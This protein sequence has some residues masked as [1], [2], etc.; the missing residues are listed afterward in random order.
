M[1]PLKTQKSRLPATDID[2]RA[3]LKLF[4]SGIALS[5]ASCSKPVEEIVPYVEQPE[6]LVPGIPLRFATALDLA[7]FSR[8]VIVTSVEGRPIKIEGNPRH[9]ASLGATDVFAEAAVLS[10]Y[11][12]D[13]SKTP[14]GTIDVASWSD[15]QSALRAQMDKESARG[16]AG[17]RIVSGRVT[18]P[19]LARQ[20]DAL[21]KQFPQAR[22]YGYEPV[23]D[24]VERAGAVIAFGRPLT[25]VPRIR[26]ASVVLSLDNDWLGAGP[27]QIMHA[28]GFADARN[29]ASDPN[30][31]LRLYVAEPAWTA[32]GANADHRLALRPDEIG[33]V[34]IAIAAHLR[35]QSLS[36]QLPPAAAKFARYAAAD[37]QAHHGSA[38]VVAGRSQSPEIHALSHWIN[39]ALAA[40]VDLIEPIDPAP[41]HTDALRS[42][43]NDLH[44]GTVETLIVLDRNPFYDAPGDLKFGDA[45]AKVQFTVHLGQYHDESAV[46]CRWH[47]PLSHA[48]ES[49]SD[50][51][52]VDG[53]A[54]IVQPLIR[55]LYDTRTLHEVVAMISGALTPSSYNIVRDT[56]RPSATGDF[57]TWWRQLLHDGVVQDTRAQPVTATPKEI[58]VAPTNVASDAPLLVAPDPALW[59]GRHANNAWLQECPKPMT[60]HVWG[61][62][63]SLSVNDARR[64]DVVDGDVVELRVGGRSLE[65]PVAV[66]AGQADGVYATTLGYGRTHAGAIGNGIGFDVNPLR[67]LDTPW[68]IENVTLRKTGKRQ[69]IPETQSHFQ[70][71]AGADDIL[72]AV[73]LAELAN[74]L[75]RKPFTPEPKPTLYAPYKYD[76]YAWAMVIDTAVCIGCNACVIAC[77]AENN[78]PVVGPEQIA[79]GRDMHWL[80]VDVYDLPEA[81]GRGFQP[82]P[83][84]QCEQAPCEPV[85]PVE[86]SV[87]D[88]EGIN[89]QVY[90]RCIGTR[91]CQSNCPYKVRR[92]NWFGYAD[93]EEYKN[94]GA[95]SIA[96]QHNPNVTVRA[97]GVMEKCTY[98]VQRISAARRTAEKEDRKIATGE[99]VTACQAACPTRA[100]HFGD[101]NNAKAGI[102]ALRK[103][104]QHYELLGHLGT[105]PRTTYLARLRNL[106]PAFG[107][108]SA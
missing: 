98:C 8:G 17:L 78:V 28:R 4:A 92:F 93:G 105:R 57:E 108:T 53:T 18:S 54:S 23:T 37:L 45:I 2:R 6:R 70:I 65:A 52:A 103:E 76:T 36:V 62:L 95:E 9:P 107:E 86:A 75:N 40:P 32:T 81:S 25:A 30:K 21:L 13:R 43:T 51:R 39:H 96:A 20:R 69:T 90:N 11:D 91:F 56:W 67:S 80:R 74:G 106:N 68:L 10:L 1:P 73:S 35:G 99:V 60:K 48:L 89:D 47:L 12:P 46:R 71:D 5:L 100:I 15:F 34:A 83:C 55:P 49:W 101:L 14:R 26:D 79:V 33:N 63:L 3:A 104:K 85:C 58:D 82:V 77:Q 94:L 102:H 88:G 24:D 29:P 72:P 44:G 59:D 38:L 7:G 16:G 50:V 66:S 64:L 27:S 41:S 97:R 31:F 87:H 84:M 42:L 61:N 22:W 19:T